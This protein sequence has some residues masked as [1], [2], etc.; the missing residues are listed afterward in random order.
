MS[1][2]SIAPEMESPT[3]HTN[4]KVEH[5]KER[6]MLENIKL[7]PNEEK[8]LDSLLTDPAKLEEYARRTLLVALEIDDKVESLFADGDKPFDKNESKESFRLRA[9]YSTLRQYTGVSIDRQSPEESLETIN[10]YVAKLKYRPYSEAPARL[11]SY[12]TNEDTIKQMEKSSSAFMEMSE[13]SRV[14]VDSTEDFV[15]PF[16][17]ENPISERLNKELNPEVAASYLHTIQDKIKEVDQASRIFKALATLQRVEA[18]E[19]S[20]DPTT[21]KTIPFNTYA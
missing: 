11:G 19:A 16:N 15:D 4:G 7:E 12:A 14:I 20:T 18:E 13:L 21:F 3:P 10:G 5:P 6:D 1:M 2:F 17:N 9:V 8:L